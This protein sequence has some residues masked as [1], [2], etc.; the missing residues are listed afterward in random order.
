[1]GRGKYSIYGVFEPGNGS[2]TPIIDAHSPVE[3]ICSGASSTTVSLGRI[4]WVSS[5]SILKT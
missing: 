5:I 3:G 1:M 4:S 2:K